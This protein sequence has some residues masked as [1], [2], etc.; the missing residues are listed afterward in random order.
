MK[1]FITYFKLFCSFILMILASIT[2]YG[3]II[4]HPLALMFT[5][6]ILCILTVVLA[7]ITIDLIQ[8][9]VLKYIRNQKK[10]NKTSENKEYIKINCH[11]MNDDN[12]F[13]IMFYADTLTQ[14]IQDLKDYC[15]SRKLHCTEIE[16]VTTSD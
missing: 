10:K 8:T 11:V 1:N 2:L 6:Y 7:V 12:N 14:C 4:E 13:H 9:L 15:N 3:M 16:L 5:T